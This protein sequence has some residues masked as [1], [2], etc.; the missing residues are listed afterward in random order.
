MLLTAGIKSHRFLTTTYRQ[1]VMSKPSV[2]LG[3]RQRKSIYAFLTPSNFIPVINCTISVFYP[4]H[5]WSLEAPIEETCDEVADGLNDQFR[6][7]IAGK[8]L[9]SVPAPDM[10]SK[11]CQTG[12]W[13]VLTMIHLCHFWHQF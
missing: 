10:A 8:N 12:Q 6:Q 5:V 13:N 1:K 11:M 4:S 7:L 2:P 3:F 9:V